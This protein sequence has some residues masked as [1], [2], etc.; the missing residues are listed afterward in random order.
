MKKFVISLTQCAVMLALSVALSFVKLWSMPLG[1]SVTLV[2]MLPICLIAIKF[3]LPQGLGTAFVYSLFQLLQA[4][5]EGDVFIY[6][7]GWVTVVVCVFFD[8]LLPFTVLG[9][10]G[11][12]K[13]FHLLHEKKSG[14]IKEIRYFGIYLGLSLAVFL[15]FIC[16]FVTGVVI[17]GQWAP[18]GM[19]KFGY[20]L[21][22]NGGYLLPELILTL[23]VTALVLAN[24]QM[25]KLLEI[26]ASDLKMN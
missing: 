16:H 4:I 13:K 21:L 24:S 5:I 3:G 10:A 7:E 19:G 23:I 12:F 20:S 14:E 8:Y 25:K 22:Y 26:K 18:D 1:G 6:C 17:W 2:S 9:L 15:R 11:I